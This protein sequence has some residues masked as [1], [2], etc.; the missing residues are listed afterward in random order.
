MCFIA[1][2]YV[3]IGTHK[4]PKDV[5]CGVGESPSTG[6]GSVTGAVYTAQWRSLQLSDPPT[7]DELACCAAKQSW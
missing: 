3:M 7:T 6:D 5:G 4:A 2:R 1:R